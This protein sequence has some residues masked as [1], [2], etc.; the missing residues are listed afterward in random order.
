MLRKV[1]LGG[2]GRGG[3]WLTVNSDTS[4]RSAP[5]HVADITAQADQLSA[6]FAPESIDIIRC[7]HTLEHLPQWDIL[8]TLKYWREFLKPDGQLWIVVPDLGT[9]IFEYMAGLIP[10][11]VFIS[12]AYVP[13]SRTINRPITEIH[14]WGWDAFT[15]TQDLENV[16]Y[17]DIDGFNV[18]DVWVPTWT[19][20]FEDLRHTGLVG[21]YQVPNLRVK[22]FK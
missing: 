6:I 12:V 11:S 7:V 13:P 1:D 14:R 4:V 22:A 16:G 15:L 18:D 10:F 21:K 20:D 19:L 9:M 3:E 2:I 17:K 8:P 5:D